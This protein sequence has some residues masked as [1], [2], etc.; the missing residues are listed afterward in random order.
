MTMTMSMLGF[1]FACYRRP[2]PVR[3]GSGIRGPTENDNGERL[4][5]RNTFCYRLSVGVARW[6]LTARFP[7]K[8]TDLAD[9]AVRSAQSIAVNI[10]EGSRGG[11]AGRNHY[12]IAMG[13]AAELCTVLDLVDLPEGA[14]RQAEL[15]RIGGMPRGLAG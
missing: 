4:P 7:P 12:R 5:S 11:Q 2:P 9:Q 1:S 8:C 10:A 6:V 14:A 15:R 13:S 3:R